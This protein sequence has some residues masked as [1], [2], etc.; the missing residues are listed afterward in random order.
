MDINADIAQVIRY[1]QQENASLSSEVSKLRN[2]LQEV[3]SECNLLEQEAADARAQT[4]SVCTLYPETSRIFFA[5]IRALWSALNGGAADSDKNHLA[6]HALSTALA[7]ADKAQRRLNDAGLGNVAVA[8]GIDQ[9]DEVLR[10][11]SQQAIDDLRNE[12]RQIFMTA[13]K[14]VRDHA[15]VVENELE[16]CR[17]RCSELEGDGFGMRAQI[18]QLQ[19]QIVT[20]QNSPQRVDLDGVSFDADSIR[21]LQA[22]LQRSQRQYADLEKAHASS[23]EAAESHLKKVLSNAAAESQ[24]T[25]Q[26][27]VDAESEVSQL[28]RQAEQVSQKHA[29]ELAEQ[30]AKVASLERANLALTKMAQ[31]S[32][33]EVDTL[34]S[35]CLFLNSQIDSLRVQLADSEGR[36][37]KLHAHKQSITKSAA[38]ALR[39]VEA[40]VEMLTSAVTTMK[41]K[42]QEQPPTGAASLP[43][44]SASSGHSAAIASAP[45]STSAPAASLA[46]LPPAP[47][48]PPRKG[49]V[50]AA[51]PSVT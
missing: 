33:N 43:S 44:S 46:A 8:T 12:E 37:A 28:K 5:A 51:V 9:D 40:Q 18:S 48:P 47:P 42:K 4:E 31:S 50:A 10:Q 15:G 7:H 11:A 39:E 3:V 1:L 49:A 21:S 24:A 25:L 35:K 29:K 30:K 23:K 34:Q 13:L 20:L 22:E 27:A 45:V 14:D 2:D 41:N 38:A 32:Q 36:L 6:Q 26:R 17:R 19:H 16:T